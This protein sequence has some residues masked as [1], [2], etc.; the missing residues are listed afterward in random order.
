MRRKGGRAIVDAV[1]AVLSRVT[2]R[3][4]QVAHDESRD[5]VAALVER[6]HSPLLRFLSRQ[7]GDPELAADLAQE[8]FL[9]A[10]R[11]FDGLVDERAVAGWLF[12]IARNQ[13][14]MEWRR[15]RI[16]RLISLDWLLTR[17][18]PAPHAPLVPDEAEPSAERDAIQ[19]ILDQL[20][21]AL[22]EALLLHS[23]CGFTGGEVAH[24]L[25]ISPDAARKRI[26]R[27][28]AAFRDRYLQDVI[29]ARAH[30]SL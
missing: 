15:R 9:A 12:A 6:F 11:S 18:D 22:R 5:E 14:R 21:P 10:F 7:T 24:I 17:N 23:L 27:A 28:E 4:R 19:R 20:N 3:V 2:T 13:L 1:D 8:T 16:R 25:G 30:D 26:L 29:E